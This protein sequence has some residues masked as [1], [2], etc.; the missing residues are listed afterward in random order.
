MI[1]D[2]MDLYN[3]ICVTSVSKRKITSLGAKTGEIDGILNRSQ[4]LTGIDYNRKLGTLAIA[5]WDKIEEIDLEGK[6]T[7][8]LEGFTDIHTVFYTSDDTFL[9]SCAKGAG[10]RAHC[11][12]EFDRSGKELFS[13]E[14]KEGDVVNSAT[15]TK[16]GFLV[17]LIYNKKIVEI[18]PEGN[19][20]NEI[21]TSFIEDTVPHATSLD[22]PVM[23]DGKIW[24][25]GDNAVYVVDGKGDV[26]NKFGGFLNPMGLDFLGS[27]VLVA[28][29][30]AHSVSI[31]DA[32][33]GE[34]EKRFG[35]AP[36]P[37]R[38]VWVKDT[39]FERQGT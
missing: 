16:D 15:P 38:A 12:I 1:G 31:L 34:I 19:I 13:W 18:S 5:E 7:D 6:T 10:R 8:V 26:L 14:A 20:L 17:S 30:H 32:K 25:S 39:S 33:S 24:F 28:E 3:N 27:K 35:V 29:N 21:D 37:F 4:R 23:R 22:N 36:Y 2:L 9:V 11:V